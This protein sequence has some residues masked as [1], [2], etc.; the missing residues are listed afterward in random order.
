M[1]LKSNNGN[2]L[3]LASIYKLFH[4]PNQEVIIFAKHKLPDHVL[5]WL[6]LNCS[7]NVITIVTAEHRPTLT[8]LNYHALATNQ[9]TIYAIRFYT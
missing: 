7:D 8:Y 9:G 5:N 4:I 6:A 3:N 2:T 1:Y